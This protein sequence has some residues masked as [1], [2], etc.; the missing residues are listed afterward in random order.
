MRQAQQ[1]DPMAEAEAVAQALQPTDI[2][3]IVLIAVVVFYLLPRQVC[4]RGLAWGHIM[5]CN[6][7]VSAVGLEVVR[8]TCGTPGAPLLPWGHQCGEQRSLCA[9]GRVRF[10]PAAP[11]VPPQLPVSCARCWTPP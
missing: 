5:P 6:R 11:R 7:C 4:D 8:L 10:A 3:L 2:I 1:A 9:Q